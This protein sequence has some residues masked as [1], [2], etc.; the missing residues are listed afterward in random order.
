MSRHRLVCA[1]TSPGANT[2]PSSATG[3]VP[4]TATTLPTRN[5]REKPICALVRRAGRPAGGCAH[6][7][8]MAARPIKQQGRSRGDDRAMTAATSTAHD[9]FADFVDVLA[10][11]LDDHDATGEELAA[12]LLPVAVPLR[13]DGRV[14]GRRAAAPVPP[15]DPARAG[16]VPADHHRPRRSS[17]S[18]S[19]RA[20]ARTRRSPARSPRRTASRRPPWRSAARPHPDRGAQRRPLPPTRQHPA[21]RRDKVTP[22]DLLTRMVE[23]HVWLT[24][25]IVRVRRAAH[26]RAARR[27]D[28]AQRRRR[29]RP[30]RRCA[31]CCP[32]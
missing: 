20:T 32:G 6:V 22:M 2:D 28:R 13:P 12:R 15:A 26:R 11:A 1:C 24:G 25:E 10:D 23:H 17:T 21:A 30:E 4:D 18:P 3:A 7:P 8:R 19:R 29:P 31:G 9:T 27:A 14:G 16:G 5:A